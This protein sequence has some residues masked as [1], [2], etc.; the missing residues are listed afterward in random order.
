MSAL[1]LFASLINSS[2]FDLL[3]SESS[4]VFNSTITVCGRAWLQFTVVISRMC[5]SYPS[6]ICNKWIYFINW[7][8]WKGDRVVSDKVC[9]VRKLLYTSGS[10][11]LKERLLYTLNKLFVKQVKSFYLLLDPDPFIFLCLLQNTKYIKFTS[12]QDISIKVIQ[13]SHSLFP[14]QVIS[15]QIWIYTTCIKFLQNRSK[16]DP[17]LCP[18]LSLS[19][20]LSF[21]PL[22]WEPKPFRVVYIV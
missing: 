1:S 15:V 7:V 2:A 5:R 19:V 14:S 13:L 18:T 10:V 12:L 11:S 9:V 16:S 21:F 4:P 17:K 22:L 3:N 20:S 6:L 8:I